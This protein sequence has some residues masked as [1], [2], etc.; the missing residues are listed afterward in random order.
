MKERNERQ[1]K[2][3]KKKKKK[4]NKAK[5]HLGFSL[6]TEKIFDTA[7]MLIQLPGVVQ[8]LFGTV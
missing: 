1:K 7:S 3:K 5:R 4:E 8:T 2:K 6:L